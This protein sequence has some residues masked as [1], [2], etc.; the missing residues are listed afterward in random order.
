LIYVIGGPARCGKTELAL[1]LL[2]A[3]S[4]PIFSTDLFRAFME[5]IDAGGPQPTTPWSD[6]EYMVQAA[7]VERSRERIRLHLPNLLWM[8]RG[9][10]G[11]AIF[12]GVEFR[13]DDIPRLA[14]SQDVRAVFL[15]RKQVELEALVAHSDRHDW[16]RHFGQPVQIAIMAD[17]LRQSVD[18]AERGERHRVAVVDVSGDFQAA[19]A[20]AAEALGLPLPATSAAP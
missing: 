11:S 4:L 14:D 6:D 7:R 8:V 1:R 16:L 18:I 9:V 17:I 13:P 3:H 15:V 10:Y 12:E 2:R 5:D 19:M 20:S